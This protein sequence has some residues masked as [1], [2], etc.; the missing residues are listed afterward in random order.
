MGTIRGDVLVDRPPEEVFTHLTNLS[1][2][3]RWRQGYRSIEVTSDGPVGE[4]TT[5]RFV[6]QML[7]FLRLVMNAQVSEY[8]PGKKFSMESHDTAPF[9][10]TETL[11]LEA[12]DGGTRVSIEGWVNFKGLM[13]VFTP[14]MGLFGNSMQRA[15]LRKFKRFVEGDL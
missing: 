8:E 11:V 13:R 6:A 15:E 7:P 14:V 10:W 4:G 9:P 12:S 3:V 5:F 2:F 1:E